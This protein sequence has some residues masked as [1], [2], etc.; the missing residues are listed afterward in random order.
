MRRYPAMG[1][2]A[3]TVLCLAFVSCLFAPAA[4]AAEEKEA[5]KA[6]LGKR[7]DAVITVKAI[8]KL[9]MSFG[10]NEQKQESE[11]ETPA[12]VV[13]PSGLAVLSFSSI[14]PAR[15]YEGIMKNLRSGADNPQV[16]INTDITSITMI[17][18][19]GREIPAKLVLKDADLD[20]AFVRP[21]EKQDKPMAAIDLSGGAR[22][23]V[24]DSVMIMT[25]L[26]KTL[27]RVPAISLLHIDGQA[28]RA[29]ILHGREDS[30]LLASEN[31]QDER[32]GGRARFPDVRQGKRARHD[33]R[34][35]PCGR[36]HP[37]REAGD[38][39]EDVEK[40]HLDTRTTTLLGFA[41]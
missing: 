34:D 37:C 21:T 18:P 11:T 29:G 4:R 9:R 27:G 33:T 38:R 32:Q 2:F 31:L 23:D 36:R 16:S 1:R 28:R 35:T 30:G 5:A 26:D 40:G 6:I 3:L 24:L 14:D 20:L 10:G 17:M 41:M 19:D 7:A 22:L 8:V 15:A 39:D 25:R 13:D 12:T